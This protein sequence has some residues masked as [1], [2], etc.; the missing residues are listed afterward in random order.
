VLKPDHQ[1]SLASAYAEISEL[2]RLRAE[3]ARLRAVLDAHGIDFQ[4]SLAEPVAPQQSEAP[5]WD[6]RNW[7]NQREFRV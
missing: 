2:E 1:L 3:N 7:I 4:R 6:T 5:P